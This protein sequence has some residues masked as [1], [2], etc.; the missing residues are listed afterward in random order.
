MVMSFNNVTNIKNNAVIAE[1]D[2]ISFN[3]SLEKLKVEL[4][5]KNK[6]QITANLTE[7]LSD[8][9]PVATNKTRLLAL[10]GTLSLVGVDTKASEIDIDSLK[11]KIEKFASAF[12]VDGKKI[13]G[14]WIISGLIQNSSDSKQ[15]KIKEQNEVIDKARLQFRSL[16]AS[17]KRQIKES[18]RDPEK[19]VILIKEKMN[20][21]EEDAK[22]YAQYRLGRTDVSKH[23]K[24]EVQIFHTMVQDDLKNGSLDQDVADKYLNAIN[25]R[26]TAI[27]AAEAAANASAKSQIGL[28][29]ENETSKSFLTDTAKAASKFVMSS[30]KEN[31]SYQ[32]IVDLLK[33]AKMT[34]EEFLKSVEKSKDFAESL[35]KLVDKA[36]ENYKQESALALDRKDIPA[37]KLPEI[38]GLIAGLKKDIVSVQNIIKKAISLAQIKKEDPVVI[39]FDDFKNSILKLVDLFNSNSG[40]SETEKA[41]RMAQGGTL[42]SFVSSLT[43]QGKKDLKQNMD[44]FE[45]KLSQ[46]IER[47]E[48]FLVDNDLSN[49][50]IKNEGIVMKDLGELS[51]LVDGIKSMMTAAT[52]S[53]EFSV[54]ENNL[55]MA[56]ELQDKISE[57]LSNKEGALA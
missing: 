48:G 2:Q 7:I 15:S 42:A 45:K 30:I 46:M 31:Q 38:T 24:E 41:L 54:M 40:N 25:Q 52:S 6:A 32:I 36:Y 29:D 19:L 20:L 56:L 8:I 9:K 35:Q 3:N 14:G 43:L 13:A 23:S 4:N 11:S 1:K 47:V 44:N 49:L 16:D 33:E 51:K 50:N 53:K 55:S 26:L 37:N 27:K 21:S 5:N 10:A 22:I 28:G 34:M 39:K 12:N 18:Q 17:S 57:N